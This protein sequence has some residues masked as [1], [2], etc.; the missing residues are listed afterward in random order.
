MTE[1]LRRPDDALAAPR[2]E[3]GRVYPLLLL[4]NLPASSR[5]NSSVLWV[6]HAR[7]LRHLSWQVVAALPKHHGVRLGLEL[8]AV[9]DSSQMPPPRTA[10]SR[11]RSPCGSSR[12][13]S[14]RLLLE[15]RLERR[16]LL[17]FRALPVQLWLN[18][19][20]RRM[21]SDVGTYPTERVPHFMEAIR[22]R[23]V[24]K[25]KKSMLPD[26]D[27]ALDHIGVCVRKM[28]AKLLPSIVFKYRLRTENG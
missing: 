12:L 8:V 18:F 23:W 9:I 28:E 16:L 2:F 7:A 25:G 4:A 24:R 1:W 6:F 19:I 13:P 5:A 20:V 11:S 26:S 10:A 3:P 17:F 15:R 22:R 21:M 14:W 27:P